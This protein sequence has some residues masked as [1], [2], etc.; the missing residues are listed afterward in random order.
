MQHTLSVLQRQ[1]VTFL[2]CRLFML[3]VPI[4][5]NDNH[6][7]YTCFCCGFACGQDIEVNGWQAHM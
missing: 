2:A 6:K 7:L 3:R 4:V 5:V 1:F